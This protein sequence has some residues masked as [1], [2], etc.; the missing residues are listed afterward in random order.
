VKLTVLG[1]GNMGHSVAG[2]LLAAGHELTVWNRSPGRAADLPGV[3]EA[4]SPQE[5]AAGADAVLV[6]LADDGAVRAVLLPDGGPLPGPAAVVN[7][8]TSSVA[9]TRE[10]ATA[11]A[12]RFVA[13]PILGA[14]AAVQGGTATYLLGGP[15]D[16]VD[17]LD[18]VWSALSD[19]RLRCGPDPA[20]AVILKLAS[21]ALLLAGLEVLAEAVAT[22]QGAGLDEGLVRQLFTSSSMVAPGLKNRLDDVLEGDHTHGWFAVPLGAKDLDLFVA[23]ADEAGTDVPAVTAAR[24]AYRRAAAAGL[25]DVDV[26]GVVELA[27][28]RAASASTDPA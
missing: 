6:S 27:R 20:A 3:T 9:L 12:G 18:P 16:V 4:G 13:A 11:Y 7:L 23:V 5:A 2:R 21:N 26:A 24:D 14:P 17:R 1:L 15:D 28:R 22:A 19:S 10:L 25:A 8:T